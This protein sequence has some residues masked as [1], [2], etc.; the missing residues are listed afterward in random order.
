MPVS[1]AVEARE[2]RRQQREVCIRGLRAATRR[3]SASQ[4][5]NHPT[6]ATRAEGQLYG[7]GALTARRDALQNAPLRTAAMREAEDKRRKA[8]WPTVRPPPP[9]PYPPTHTGPRG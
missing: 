5:G 4:Y 1:G 8:R 9:F 6:G 7:R 2:R 3:H